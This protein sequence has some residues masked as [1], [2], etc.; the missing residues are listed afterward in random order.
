M[1]SCTFTISSR[2]SCRRTT[3]GG[4]A[5]LHRARFCSSSPS[6][7]SSGSSAT[8][9][10]SR[11]PSWCRARTRCFRP[12]SSSAGAKATH[13]LLPLLSSSTSRSLFSSSTFTFK[14]TP[15]SRRK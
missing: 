13:G 11:R 10:C 15:R 9:T 12:L 2:V 4:A 7:C 1:C 5:T 6:L 3:R 14:R 8:S